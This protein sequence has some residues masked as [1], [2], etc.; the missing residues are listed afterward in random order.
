M[1]SAERA[2]Y[3]RRAPEYDDWWLGLGLWGGPV[4]LF[5]FVFALRARFVK[6]NA[7]VKF[8]CVLHP[9]TDQPLPPLP[10]VASS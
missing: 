6:P 5:L 4:R 9:P 10:A 7:Y 3:D 1:T 2:Y 8:H